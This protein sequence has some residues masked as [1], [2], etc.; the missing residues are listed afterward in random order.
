MAE[1]KKKPDLKARL[2]GTMAGPPPA[3]SSEPAFPPPSVGG[4]IAPPVVAPPVS[5]D[6]PPIA[7]PMASGG[8]D[9]AVPDF[10]RAQMAEKAAAEARVAAEKAAA[11][12]RAIEQARLAAEHARVAALAADPFSA[13]A[14]SSAHEVH[15]VIDD[16]HVSDAEVGR[17]RNTGA[18]LATLAVGAISL[19]AGYL[20]GDFKSSRD[21][22]SKT[23]GAITEIRRAVDAT[24][25]TVTTLKD[26]VDAA[27][28]AAGI[29]AGGEEGQQQQQAPTQARVDEELLTWFSQQ[30]PD[31]PLGPDVY[32][33]R[34]GRLRPDLVSKLMKVQIELEQVWRD[35][36]R[37]TALTSGANLQVVRSSLTEA[38]RVRTEMQ[39]LA[40][41]FGPGRGQDAPP[42]MA[43]LVVPTY[44]QT[45]GFTFPPVPG[46]TGAPRRTVYTTGDLSAAAT[47][48]TVGIPVAPGPGVVGNVVSNLGR[49]WSD[50]VQRL[51]RLRTAVDALQNDHHSLG[52]ALS[53][54]G[55]N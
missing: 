20:I 40:V 38:Q 12:A 47:I 23:R 37:H 21:E 30:S 39:H 25:A 54:A 19:V 8:D 9:I 26:K 48:G 31:P 1:E 10:I 6:V 34:V 46:L 5:V 53:R 29:A 15:L 18:I 24:G 13:S 17:G 41:I 32:A 45:G 28:T 11:E 55:V 7:P 50:Y 44:D 2:K 33:G 3:A 43:T 36:Q 49:P 42:V 14:T 35:M 4:D 16:K 51:T 27:A 22:E 52:E